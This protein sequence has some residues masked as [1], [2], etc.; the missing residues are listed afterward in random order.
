MRTFLLLSMM[1]LS[2]VQLSCSAPEVV[3]E[4]EAPAPE[5]L[6]PAAWPD[7]PDLGVV[8]SSGVVPLAPPPPP[9]DFER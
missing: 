7:A 3:A 9:P 4:T 6:A 2:V 8:V 1:L 5:F